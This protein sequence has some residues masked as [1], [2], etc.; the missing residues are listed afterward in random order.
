MGLPLAFD[1]AFGLMEDLTCSNY[2]HCTIFSDRPFEQVHC[3]QNS[4]D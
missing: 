3:I 4:N 1:V 2:I